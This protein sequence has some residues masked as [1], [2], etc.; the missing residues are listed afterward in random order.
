METINTLMIQTIWG[1]SEDEYVE[2]PAVQAVGG[3]VCSWSKECFR[4][5]RVFRGVGYLGV[6]GVWK[7]GDISIVI[8]NVYL[9]CDLTEKRNMW[10]EIKEIRSVS[11]ISR[12]LVAGDFNEVRRDI[13]RQGIRG[14]SRRSQSTEFNEF[15]ADMDLEEVRIVGRSFTWYKLNGTA[16]SKLD[17][18]LV[19]PEWVTQWSR[20]TQYILGRNVS[21][22]CPIILKDVAQDWGP[23]PFRTV[24]CWLEDE[25]FRELVQKVWKTNTV[26]GWAAF[27]LKEKLK[28]LKREIK[29]WKETNLSNLQLKIQQV[30]ERINS[31]DKKTIE[32][33]SQ[34]GLRQG[35]PLVPFLFVIVAEGLTSLMREATQKGM[36]KGYKVGKE[37]VDV[38]LLQFADDTIFFGEATLN[39]VITVKS[40]LRCYELV[41]GLKVNFFKSRCGAIETSSTNMVRFATIL[42]C[43][44]LDIPFTYLGLHIR[45]NP[46]RKVMW[47]HVIH[48]LQ[49][50]LARGKNKLLSMAGRVCLINSVLSSLP[51]FY[52]SFYK[53]PRKVQKEVESIQRK[54][55]W[56]EEQDHRKVAWVSWDKICRKKSQGGLGI[57]Y[58][59]LFNDSLLAK[60]R[61]HMYH[62]RSNLWVNVLESKYGRWVKLIEGD[63]KKDYSMWWRD[64]RKVCGGD[65]R[66][67]WFDKCMNWKVKNGKRTRFWEDRWIGQQILV[68]D[69]PRLYIN[70]GQQ[71][72]TIHNMGQWL[73][74]G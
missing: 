17:R 22:H 38:S 55:L 71:Q 26:G 27:K 5:G 51:I 43:K 41:L 64:L 2:A 29:S 60:W 46:R 65:C 33:Q 57:K 54:F 48:K 14:A 4:L 15:I 63:N 18:F 6:Q 49:K 3:M 37:R 69:Y 61:W 20:S 10:N 24:D 44:I 45:D 9:P 34:R 50:R 72:A 8:V 67:Q 68:E 73:E 1:D 39:N 21:D 52:F 11:N 16:R 59:S 35:D 28:F 56:G 62:D 53:M 13:E 58:L 7:Q 25:G 47:K 23:R 36:F 66:E 31:L 74:G 12:W 19:S 30:E 42:N 32:F 40:I 70:S